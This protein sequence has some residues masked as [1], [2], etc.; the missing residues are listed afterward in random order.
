M[1]VAGR[2][3]AEVLDFIA[4][5][6]KPGVTTGELNDLCH[7]YMVQGAGHHPGAAQLCAAGLHAVPEVDLHLGQPRG[8]PRHPGRQG[9]EDGR[10]RSTSTSPSSRTASTATPAACSSSA[11]RRIQAQAPVRRH[12]RM[13][14]ARHP[15]R[16]ARARASATSARDPGARREARLLGGA[17]VLRPRHRPQVPRGAAGAALRQPGHGLRAAS[18]A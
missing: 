6:V 5:H 12:L 17:R 15:R 3:A 9:A 7:D 13:H 8:L 4:P 2:L 1:R 10:H 16:C 18:R 14:V 11:S